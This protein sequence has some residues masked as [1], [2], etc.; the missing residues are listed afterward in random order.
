[1]V[2]SSAAHPFANP[3]KKCDLIMKGGI[4]SGVVFPQAICELAREYRFVCIGGTS[5]GAIGAVMAAAAEYRRRKAI[6]DPAKQGAGFE[7]IAAMPSVLAANLP[8]F[9]QPSPET[10]PLFD[11]GMAA[12]RARGSKIFAVLRQTLWGFRQETSKGAVLGLLVM[13][14]S[15]ATE[16]IAGLL[17]GL[18]LALTGAAIMVGYALYKAVAITLPQHDFGLCSGLTQPGNL[19]PGFTDWIADEIQAVAGRT[20][21]NDPLTIGDLDEEN[22]QVVSVTT[23]LSSRRP[24]ELPFGSDVFCFRKSEFELLFPTWIM[25]YLLRVSSELPVVAYGGARDFYRLPNKKALPVAMIARMSLSFPG[26]IRAVPLYRYDRSLLSSS[27]KLQLAPVRCLFSDGGITSNFPIHLFDSL[28]PGR[29][30]FGIS[31]ASYDSKRHDGRVYMPNTKEAGADDIDRTPILPVGGLLDFVSAILSTARN[32]QDTLQ[33]QLH[34]YSERIVEIRL[35]DKKEGG[36]N[37][38]MDDEIIGTLTRLGKDAGGAIRQNFDFNEHR[39]RRAATALPT[40]AQSLKKLH[41]RYN[42]G[43]GLEL[44]DLD[45]DV[46][47]YATILSSYQPTAFVDRPMVTRDRLKAFAEKAAAIGAKI[48]KEAE[49]SATTQKANLRITASMETS[50]VAPPVDP[51]APPRQTDGAG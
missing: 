46:M 32:W 50:A 47:D 35:D 14:V 37:L 49:A 8:T 18:L 23:D 6:D 9:F 48:P 29:P 30:T 28:L 36:L 22:I 26:L 13:A 51:A 19:K 34:G 2:D 43:P 44:N 5:A 4:T 1:M 21:A 38:D 7:R 27:E 11:I 40:L 15:I 10:R 3:P 45:A 17:L 24:Y 12:I 39:W 42:A 20:T 16:S 33:S 25:D 41:E 31:L